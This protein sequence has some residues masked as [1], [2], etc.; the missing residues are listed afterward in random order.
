MIEQIKR[1]NL[2]ENDVLIVTIPKG[3]S[4][5]KTMRQLKKISDETGINFYAIIINEGTE[6]KIMSKTGKIKLKGMLEKSLRE[7]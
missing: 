7:E 4:T 5:E 3:E 1:L 2:K 6:F